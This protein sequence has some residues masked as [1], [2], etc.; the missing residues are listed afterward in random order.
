V[1]PKSCIHGT[2]AGFVEPLPACPHCVGT[3]RVD[4]NGDEYPPG[5]NACCCTCAAC[6]QA[7]YAEAVRTLILNGGIEGTIFGVSLTTD[8]E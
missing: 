3:G 2:H 7:A 4:Y 1:I 8:P 5:T 6:R